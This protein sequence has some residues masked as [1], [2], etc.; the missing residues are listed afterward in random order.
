MAATRD[1]RDTREFHRGDRVLHP[2]FGIGV[3]DAVHLRPDGKSGTANYYHIR[4][5]GS[6]ML[7]VPVDKAADL[8]LRRLVNTLEAILS[9]L[10]GAGAGKLPLDARER[11]AELRARWEAPGPTVL[12]ETMRDLLR[13]GRKYR[14]SSADK[15]WLT[16]AGE[17]LSGEAAIVDAIELDTAREAI[18][19]EV[20][21][22]KQHLL[23]APG[24]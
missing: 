2:R 22:L 14:L 4:L 5:E 20:E 7:F 15:L 23:G 8:G 21:V 10:Q 16:R 1:T 6:G 9:C 17:R 3:I 18:N 24:R 12:A 19:R 13:F 11:V